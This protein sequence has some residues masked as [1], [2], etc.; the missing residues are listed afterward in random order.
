[1]RYTLL[2]ATLLASVAIPAVAISAMAQ[3][4]AKPAPADKIA[5]NDIEIPEIIVTAQKRSQRLSEVPLAVSVVGGESFENQG[6][7]TIDDIVGTVPSLSFGASAT[8]RGEGLVIRGFGTTSFSDAA[9]GA[10]GIVVDGVTI[11]RQASG[12]IDLIDIERVEVLRGPQGTL[13]GKNSSAGLINITTRKPSTKLEANARASYGTDNELRLAGTVSGPVVGDKVLARITAFRN[14]RDGNINQK[15]PAFAT[16][17]VNDVNQW[18]LRGKLELR[19]SDALTVTLIGEYQKQD[20]LCCNWTRRSFA[21][22]GISPVLTL[23]STALKPFITPGEGNRD[24]ALSIRS[25]FQRSTTWAGTL[26]VSLAMGEHMLRSIT[27]YRKFDI[28]EGN[29]TDQLPVSFFNLA[30]T[31]SKIKQWSQELQLISPDANA[32]KY[33]FGLFFFKL[34]VDSVQQQTG[35][36]STLPGNRN[37]PEAL[38]PPSLINVFRPTDRTNIQNQ[39]QETVNYAG[40]GQVS[41]DFTPK[42]TATVG[43]RVLRESLDVYFDRS[44]GLPLGAFAQRIIPGIDPAKISDTAFTGTGSLRYEFTDN[45]S[46]YATYARGY[47]GQAYDLNAG[48]P[49]VFANGQPVFNALKPEKVDNYEIGL[50]S[51]LLDRRLQ[52]NVTAFNTNVANYQAAAQRTDGIPGFVLS[53]VGKFRTRGVE[54]EMLAR[55]SRVL[56][57]GA[58]LAIIDAKYLNFPNGECPSA[59]VASRPASCAAAPAGTGTQDLSGKQAA[60]APRVSGA[61]YTQAT[62]PVTDSLDMIAWGQMTFRSDTQ[63]SLT[64]DPSTIQDGYALLNARLTLRSAAGYE[65]SFWGRNMTGKN[66]AESIFSTPVFSGGYSQFIAS[67][68]EYGVEG[69]VKF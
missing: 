24:V 18:G 15:N 5:S 53:N 43:A 16:S 21:P 62:L 54:F 45:V 14:T 51:M 38:V 68:R 52:I 58:N 27:G 63:F 35:S 34:N 50:R 30:A 31:D 48:S 33:T 9:E 41:Y 56:E 25:N 37:V 64:Q 1:M 17:K 46:A 29:K 22:A 19:A 61:V 57:V 40:Y 12:L 36:Y 10:V 66:Y 69:K 49:V 59:F 55:P 13:F 44:G 60:N 6:F 28:S 7:D 32:L 39:R 3:T 4:S 65:L 2:A 42:F 67:G 8:S 47:K 11:G 26:D 20:T 23:E